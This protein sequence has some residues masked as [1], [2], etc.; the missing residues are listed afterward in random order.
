MPNA[1][2]FLSRTNGS[3][4]THIENI[5]AIATHLFFYEEGEKEE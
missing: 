4:S 2:V 5:S 1:F 3:D